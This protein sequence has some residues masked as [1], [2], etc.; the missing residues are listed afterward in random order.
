[1]HNG[2]EA[3]IFLAIVIIVANVIV[4]LIGRRGGGAKHR[5]CVHCGASHPLFARFCRRCGKPL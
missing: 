5:I 2:F 4:R 1:M 3:L